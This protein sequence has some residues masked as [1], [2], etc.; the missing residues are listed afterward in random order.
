LSCNYLIGSVGMAGRIGSTPRGGNGGGSGSGSFASFPSSSSSYKGSGSF[1][2]FPSSS[3][4]EG[5]SGSPTKRERVERQTNF[6]VVIRVRP[7]LPREMQGDIPFQNIVAVDEREQVITVS[8]NLDAVLGPDGIL[9]SN[10]GPYS[11]HSFAF[12]HVCDQTAPQKKVYESTARTVVESALL[13]YNATI[14]AYG[15]TGT[16]KDK[17]RTHLHSIT[18]WGLPTIIN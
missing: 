18:S 12:D 9:L 6:K 15:Q 4:K 10:P 2:S 8:E 7:P 14:F 11:T 13:G 5:G 16:G 3:Y 17:T 1:A